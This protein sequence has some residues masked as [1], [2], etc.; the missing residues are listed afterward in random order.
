M[1]N[2]PSSGAGANGQ[3]VPA[4]DWKRPHVAAIDL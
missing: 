3:L 1:T 2:T 4:G